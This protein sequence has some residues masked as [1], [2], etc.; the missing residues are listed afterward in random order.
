[1]DCS[2]PGSSVHGNSPGQ[3]TG[4]GSSSLL[5]GIV[6]TQG[7]NPSLPHCRQ[8]LYQLSHQ[9][10]KRILEWVAY[11]FSRASSWPRS[12]TQ[13]SNQGLLH[14]RGILYQLSFEGKPQ[15]GLQGT[16]P[17][18]QITHWLEDLG[19]GSY[20]TSQRLSPPPVKRGSEQ[21]LFHRVHRTVLI[22]FS[23]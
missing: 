4:G 8:I 13:E 6:P 3:N 20:R 21:C 18:S 1:M 2:L 9:G 19:S 23:R 14:C 10:S 15:G 5:Q 11:P 22:K 16:G 17:R 12:R 7:S